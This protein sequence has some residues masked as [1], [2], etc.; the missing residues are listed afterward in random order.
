MSNRTV[1]IVFV[2]MVVVVAMALAAALFAYRQSDAPQALVR[3]T[4]VAAPVAA[5][6]GLAGEIVVA[7]LPD[8]A[9]WRPVDPEAVDPTRI[10]AYKETVE[11]AVLV[12]LDD[13]I[14]AWR[15][16]DEIAI[17]VPQIDAL[18]RPTIA[19]LET[20]LGNNRSYIGRLVD[21]PVPRSFVITVGERN[22]FANLS[23][24]E[25]DYELVGN[26]ELAWLM[27][28]ANMDRHVDYSKPDY[29]I[30]GRNGAP[31]QRGPGRFAP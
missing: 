12:A 28:V 31:G 17:A 1:R 5:G 4:R 18:Y 21:G 6:T 30:R 20:G 13:A 22:T 15:V 19:R 14:G 8:D 7:A 25:G 26:T 11:G 10:P 16:G 29:F 3:G 27:P 9:A 23:T 2:A 24:P